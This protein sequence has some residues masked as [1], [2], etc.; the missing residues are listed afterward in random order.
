MRVAVT[1][2]T[3]FVGSHLVEALRDDGHEP[4]LLVRSRAKAERLGFGGIRCVDG[5]LDDVAA[6]E[7][8]F[9][10]AEVVFHVAGLVAAR[11]AAEFRSVNETGTTNVVRAAAAAGSPRLVLVSSMAAAGPSAP[12]RPLTGNETPR[13]VTAYGRS[14]LAGERIVVASGLPY[15]ILRP[16]LVYGPRDTE[17]LRAFRAVRSGVAPVFGRGDQELSA[18]YGPDLA[19]A[20]L[21][22]AAGDA[23]PGRVYYPC[24]PERFTSAGFARAIAA[25]LD[26]TVRLIR[27]PRWL[28]RGILGVTETTARMTRKA[29]LLTRDKANEFF[30]PAWTGD[31]G[32]LTRDCGWSAAHDLVRGLAAT[33]AWYRKEGWL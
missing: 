7:E 29:T 23:G 14:K 17:V 9:R 24:H 25:A 6:L 15:T 30:Q 5:D 1:G 27:L 13:P 31:P 22:V 16:P 33:V 26:R 12:G 10:G 8:A 18:V 20:L 11:N 3:G 2:G 4:A 32:A 19:R 28:A 21:A